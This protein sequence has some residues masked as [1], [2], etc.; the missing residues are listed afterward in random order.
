MQQGKL[1]VAGICP[2]QQGFTILG[3]GSHSKMSQGDWVSCHLSVLLQNVNMMD[4]T[5][6]T[7]IVPYAS[8]G[9]LSIEKHLRSN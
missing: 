1:T 5:S 4:I 2:K 6:V 8:V 3:K 7:T 9:A